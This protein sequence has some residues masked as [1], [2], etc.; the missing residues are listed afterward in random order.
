M[1]NLFYGNINSG[2]I[3]RARDQQTLR[4]PMK[5][6]EEMMRTTVLELTR[7]ICR[8]VKA[9]AAKACKE[10]WVK[11]K[12]EWDRLVVVGKEDQSKGRGLK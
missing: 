9:V 1:K 7:E 6:Q 11:K 5:G 2:D 3:A 12:R 8:Q 4:S 10:G